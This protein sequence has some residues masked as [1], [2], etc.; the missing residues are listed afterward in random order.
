MPFR[1]QAGYKPSQTNT[2]ENQ[3]ETLRS[4]G[5]DSNRWV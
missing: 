2:R 1:K 5:I 3:R 4:A